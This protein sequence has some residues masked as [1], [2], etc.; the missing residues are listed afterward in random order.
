MEEKTT[1]INALP[2]SLEPRT[3]HFYFISLCG[4]L[5]VLVT[6]F[7]KLLVTW[8]INL[9]YLITTSKWALMV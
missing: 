6:A 9:L 8:I 2:K 3:D 1:L 4:R 7:P 5:L